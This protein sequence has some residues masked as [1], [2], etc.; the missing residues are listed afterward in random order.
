MLTFEIFDHL[1]VLQFRSV[2]FDLL[3]KCFLESCLHISWI[4]YFGFLIKKI[5]FFSNF[6]IFQNS[7]ILT[8]KILFWGD[9]NKQQIWWKKK[10]R[11]NKIR[12]IIWWAD[13]LSTDIVSPSKTTKKWLKIREKSGFVVS[14]LVVRCRIRWVRC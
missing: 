5:D 8:Q 6:C 12:E 13:K 14:K 1:E 2:Y 10:I 7:F 3:M 9:Q 4:V 11:E